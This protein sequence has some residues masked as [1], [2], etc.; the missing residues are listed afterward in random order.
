MATRPTR[1]TAPPPALRSEG[2]E[3][4]AGKIEAQLQYAT[5]D[6]PNFVDASVAYLDSQIDDFVNQA[7]SSAQGIVDAVTM[8]IQASEQAAANSAAAS[9]AGF[10]PASLDSLVADPDAEI[11]VRDGPELKVTT[12]HDLLAA[13]RFETLADSNFPGAGDGDILAN[14]GGEWA[15]K[16]NQLIPVGALLA[17]SSTT[18]PDGWLLCDGSIFDQAVY[19][20]LFAALGN[21]NVLPNFENRFVRGWTSGAGR[22]VG[23]YQEATSVAKNTIVTRVSNNGNVSTF[24]RLAIKNVI[25]GESTGTIVSGSSVS[26]TGVNGPSLA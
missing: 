21:S 5:I 18:I 22:T 25:N 14:S 23:S 4:F 15:L 17:F 24:I 8:S 7:A 12:Y 10:D 19:P 11:V 1:P 9:A 20:L 13:S 26:K 6:G 16:S 2:Q 3:A